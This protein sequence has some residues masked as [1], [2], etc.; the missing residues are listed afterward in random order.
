MF[1]KYKNHLVLHLIIFMW[2][3]TGIL[4]VLITIDAESIVWFRLVIA[5]VSLALFMYFMRHSFRVSSQ[6]RLWGILG[7]GV[8]VGLHWLSFYESIKLSTASL[9]ILC[10]STTTIHVTWLE[11]LILKKKF[12]WLEFGLGMCVIPGIYLVAN[13]FSG[14][15]FLALGIGL[16]SALFAALFAVFNAKFVEDDRPSVI[17]LYEMISAMLV[18]TVLLLVKGKI[19]S[20]LFDLS[21]SDFLWLLFLG[22]FCTSLAFLVVVQIVKILGAFTVSLSINLEP[23]YTI[24]LAI[25][26]LNENESLGPNFYIGALIILLVVLLNAFLKAPRVKKKIAQMRGLTEI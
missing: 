4:G 15:D 10:L 9:G 21:L 7:V 1:A 22:I 16:S 20:S 12:S 17:T 18:M 26:I 8:I 5:S 13:D 11:P 19:T 25:F 23:I 6:K 24:L 3:F 2:G 14:D